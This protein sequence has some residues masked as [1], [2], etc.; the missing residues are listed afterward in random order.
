MGVGINVIA[1]FCISC[2]KQKE[3]KQCDCKMH[4][5]GGGPSHL[6][7]PL[8][9]MT[10]VDAVKLLEMFRDDQKL[11]D[12][13]SRWILETIVGLLK[14]LP[15]HRD[16]Q[17]L[18]RDTRCD[19]ENALRYFAAAK[20]LP[21]NTARIILGG[22]ERGNVAEAE[23]LVAVSKLY[24]GLNVFQRYLQI[25][26]LDASCVRP[27]KRLKKAA[28][29]DFRPFV[30]ETCQFQDA[31]R[32]ICITDTPERNALAVVEVMM[33]LLKMKKTLG[34]DFALRWGWAEV[35][36]IANVQKMKQTTRTVVVDPG[37][38]RPFPFAVAPFHP[39]KDDAKHVDVVAKPAN[40]MWCMDCWRHVCKDSTHAD[41]EELSGIPSAFREVPAGLFESPLIASGNGLR[42][43][44]VADAV[45]DR[46]G[47]DEEEPKLLKHYMSEKAR[48][49][50]DAWL[51]VSKGPSGPYPIAC[52]KLEIA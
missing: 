32:A 15:G 9:G 4:H 48:K 12:A 34:A 18:D 13:A 11:G 49:H 50:Q 1:N 27:H 51:L 45:F 20:I 28:S 38:E 43:E 46:L 25:L 22:P 44:E 31:M 40:S 7:G 26:G 6:A 2:L 36:F 3:Q 16:T 47:D 42:L 17:G 14:T 29:S 30:V 8:N 5:I 24:P 19:I 10:V 41:L 37:S 39:V 35:F 52:S 33:A 21:W 23:D